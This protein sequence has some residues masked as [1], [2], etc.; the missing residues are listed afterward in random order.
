MIEILIVIC[1]ALALFLMLRH[2]PQTKV[3]GPNSGVRVAGLWQ[4]V[5][6]VK[7]DNIEE[8]QREIIR[9]QEKIVAPSEIDLAR[10]RYLENDPEIAQLLYESDKALQAQDLREA[11]S[12]ALQAIV[13][14]KKCSQAYVIV[15]RVAQL[16]GAF[17]DAREA[18]KTAVK[19]NPEN[20]EAYFG[21]GQLDLKDEN[22]SGTIDNFHKAVN[23]DRGR[24]DWHAA[25]GKAYME[26]RQFAK[27]AK[28]LKRAAALDMENKEYRVLASQAEDKQRSHSQ[29][30]RVR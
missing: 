21:L 5:F 22:K 9:G 12:L 23:L 18:Y 17:D 19:C 29:A 6:R 4:K 16:R 3:D 27:A 14:D 10:Q 7:R 28:S 11:E 30:F 25:L 8:I 26:V 13:R 20:G 24:A 1:L 2:F 15:G